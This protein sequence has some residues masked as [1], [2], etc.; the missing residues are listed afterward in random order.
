MEFS[1]LADKLFEKMRSL[2]R[3]ERD[4]QLREEIISLL[5]LNTVEMI[6]AVVE[7]SWLAVEVE[8][9]GVSVLEVLKWAFIEM[10]EDYYDR[11][12]EVPIDQMMEDLQNAGYTFQYV[13]NWHYLSIKDADD[14]PIFYG[15]GRGEKHDA[16]IE[17]AWNNLIKGVPP[18]AK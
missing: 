14:K 5:P 15:M 9:Y 7:Q 3:N 6:D 16:L 4:R 18:D 12:F 11:E 13:D 10:L 8:A 17:L 1:E 2:P